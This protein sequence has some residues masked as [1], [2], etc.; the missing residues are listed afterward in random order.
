MKERK[1]STI[2]D[3]ARVAGVSIKTVSRV[4]N[5][6]LTVRSSNREKVESAIRQTGYQPDLNARRLRTQ[7]SYLIALLYAVH[8]SNSYSSRLTYGAVSACDEAGYDL[9]VRPCDFVN[10]NDIS[11]IVEHIANRSNP[12]GYIIAPPLSNDPDLIRTLKSLDKGIVRIAPLNIDEDDCVYTMEYDGALTAMRHLMSV[13]HTKI[14]FINDLKGYGGVSRF[15]G[16]Q[17]AHKEAGLEIEPSLVKTLEGTDSEYEMAVRQLLNNENCP[18]AVFCSTDYLAMLIYRVANQLHLKIPY[19]LS[20]I[21]FDADPNSR[22]IWPP[23]STIRQPVVNLG[24]AA[25][26][27]LIYSL[28]QKQHVNH[29]QDLAC[30]LIMRS[31]CAPNL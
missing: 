23:L 21:G 20:V 8:D 26:E 2:H 22:N 27:K 24:R 14:A 18:T 11:A 4:I 15:E 19:D 3:V 31:S 9:L 1:N 5:K 12:D 13:G 6:D 16:Y 25:A 17:Q 30:E 28:I 10:Y 7:Q 29:K